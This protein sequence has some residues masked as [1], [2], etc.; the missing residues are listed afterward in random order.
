MEENS[1]QLGLTK[2]IFNAELRQRRLALGL[3]QG[4]LGK[5]AGLSAISISQ[6]E[7]FRAFPTPEMAQTLA[8]ILNTDKDTL[9]P[10]WLKEYHLPKASITEIHQI[11]SISLAEG[12]T[13]ILSLESG[14]DLEQDMDDKLL[15]AGISTALNEILSL[16]EQ[17][18]LT[19]RFGLNGTEPQTLEEVSKEFGVTRERVRQMEQKAL[20]KLRRN[21]KELK[22]FMRTGE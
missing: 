15:K 8:K 12:M 14:I 5:L 9:F 19:L 10:A 21:S 22:M 6:Y 3:K 1:F 2:S 4:E 13:E 18:I 16:R 17:K 7:T 11:T 20:S